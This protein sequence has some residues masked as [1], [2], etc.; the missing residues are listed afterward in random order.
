GGGGGGFAVLYLDLDRFKD[1][2]DAF[3]H[4]AGDALLR[5][6]GERISRPL[7]TSDTLARFGGDEFAILLPRAR[8]L[9]EATATAE[10]IRAVLERPFDLRGHRVF[11]E[12]SIGLVL[13]PQDGVDADTLLRHAD[14]AMYQ[15]K[16]TGKDIVAYAA[17]HDPQSQQ[18]LDLMSDLRHAI[19][20]DELRLHFQPQI[21]LEGGACTSLEALVRWQHPE[22]GVVP[23]AS[24]IPLAENSGFIN[25][26]GLWVIREGTRALASLPS[27]GVP[28]RLAINISA[29]NLHDAGLVDAVGSA[30]RT[31]QL[32]PGALTIEITETAVMSDTQ[33]SLDT[34]ERLSALGVRLSIDDFGIG[35]SSLAYLRRLPVNELKIDRTFVMDM[36]ANAS[37]DAIVTSV[38]G[39]GHSL[40]LSVV[41]EGVEDADTLEAL[42]AR[43]CDLAQGFH[44]ARP[45]PFDQ[46]V[47]WLR[48]RG[49]SVRSRAR[50]TSLRPAPA[51][52]LRDPRSPVRHAASRSRAR[53]S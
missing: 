9:V 47:E 43:H 23:P 16:H 8:D 45:M 18:R 12:A 50:P 35:Y 20:R 30:L 40:G 51:A 27:F 22:R 49:S 13:F 42:S 5:E 37:S 28:I 38:I 41:A 10:V 32:D 52:L 34:V 21:R 15:A 46:L 33:R 39:L 26:L 44:I 36:L 14:I 24:F 3:G 7:T 19:E 31:A 17:E 1:V 11:V 6:L 29:R 2:N 53:R 48:E 25:E 4:D